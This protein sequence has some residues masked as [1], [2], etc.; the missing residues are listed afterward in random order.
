MSTRSGVS[1]LCN[2]AHPPCPCLRQAITSRDLWVRIEPRRNRNNDIDHDQQRAL[3]V[4]TLPVTQEL[5]DDQNGQNEQSDHEDL[6]VEVHIR[7]A[8]GPADEHDE[9]CVE[10]GR[11]NGGSKAVVEGEVHLPVPGFVDRGQVLG[12]FFHER[13]QG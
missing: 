1:G 7:L 6:K 5:P 8:E 3:Q 2:G 11:L 4:I 9:G 12:G 13:E 10:E